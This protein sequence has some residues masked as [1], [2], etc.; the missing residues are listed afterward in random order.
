MHIQCLSGGPLKLLCCLTFLCSSVHDSFNS[1]SCLVY[2]TNQ[3]SSSFSLD[4][5]NFVIK[6]FI[7]K[8][9]YSY[10]FWIGIQY[11]FAL[12]KWSV[13]CDIDQVGWVSIV[14]HVQVGWERLL[15]LG[16]PLKNWNKNERHL[17]TNLLSLQWSLTFF[18]IIMEIYHKV[19]AS[20]ET[21]KSRICYL[22]A[23]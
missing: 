3:K 19:H 21:N 23:N 17:E 5:H 12:E 13:S 8:L 15:L 14:C 16:D 4:F 1:Y 18:I 11:S 9:G 20:S 10:L 6:I 7:F 2:Y 22:H